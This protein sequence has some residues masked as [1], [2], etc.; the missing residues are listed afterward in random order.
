M[1]FVHLVKLI[2]SWKQREQGNNFKKYTAHSPQ[3]HFISVVSVC[4]QTLRCSVPS[5][6]YVFSVWLLWVNSSAWSKICKLDLVFHQQNVFPRNRWNQSRLKLLT[7]WCLC[8]KCLC[9]AYGQ[10]PSITETCS[11][12]PCSQA[13]N[14]SCPWLHRT[15]SCP[16]VRTP[17][18]ACLWA[19]HTRPR[20]TWW[21]GGAVTVALEPGFPWGCWPGRCCRSGSSCT[22]W[23]RTCLSWCSAPWVLLRKYLHLSCLL[24]CILN[25]NYFMNLLRRSLLCIARYCQLGQ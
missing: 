25:T 17:K 2:I 15:C 6:W 3:V 5:C 14:V 8:G 1:N 22:W 9:D 19:R 13:S 11:T 18:R 7:V 12:W 20:T 16:S 24:V 10:L 23:P 4:E 21:F